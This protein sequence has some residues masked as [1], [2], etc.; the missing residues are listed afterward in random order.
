LNNSKTQETILIVDDN[1]TNLRV[2][3]TMLTENGYKVRAAVNGDLAL[4]SVRSVLP[5]LILLDIKMPGMNRYEVCRQFKSDDTTSEIPIIFISALGESSDKIKAF[6]AGGVDYVAKPFQIEEVLARV[7]THIILRKMQIK[8]EEQNNRLL[9]EIEERKKAENKLKELATTDALTGLYNRRQFMELSRQIL[10]AHDRYNHPLSLMMIDADHFKSVNDS[11]GH[12]VGD[13]VLQ[14]LADVG[15]NIFRRTDIFARIGGEEFAVLLPE[16]GISE[17]A[18]VAERF[19]QALEKKE[20]PTGTGFT[21]ITVSIGL[22][23]ASADTLELEDL[24]KCADRALFRAKRNGRNQI[25][26]FKENNP[27]KNT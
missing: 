25:D 6:D 19:R 26:I 11:F 2:L 5:D 13:K 22:A 4:Q 7:K 18:H 14:T 3:D 15:R 20:I 21:S 1:P 24:L 9:Q 27:V 16:T 17:S 10:K 23:A 8:L 12:D